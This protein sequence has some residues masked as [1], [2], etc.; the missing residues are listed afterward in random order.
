[1]GD[2][3]LDL[4]GQLALIGTN[5][6]RSVVE[7]APKIVAGAVVVALGLIISKLVAFSFHKVLVRVRFDALLEKLGVTAPLK[8]LGIQQ[9]AS[10]FLPRLTFYVLA[11]LLLQTVADT[12]GL[13]PI[14]AAIAGLFTFLPNL[15]AAF[16]L[17]LFGSMAAQFAGTAVSRVALDSGMEF[18][19]T[20]GRI[21][22]ALILFV[23][24]M[25]AIAQ[26]Q[27]ETGMVRIVTAGLL[28]GIAIAFGLS[29]GLGTRDFT[30]NIIAGHYA[31][32]FFQPGE[33]IEIRGRRGVLKAITP[34][35]VL[36]EENGQ[37]LLIS[38]SVFLEEIVR[39]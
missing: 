12:L 35:Y 30:R 7:A 25:M 27:I 18:G 23:I 22:S 34:A 24:A 36:I 33:P 10:Q 8:K 1:M 4:N 3:T 39:Q 11:L 2:E 19:P 9:P 29:F 32:K 21:V 15:C 17:L 28:T 6:V 5:M 13:K 31:R 38:N 37:T 14:S 20:L 26:L 16:L